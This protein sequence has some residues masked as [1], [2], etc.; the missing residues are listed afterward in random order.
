MMRGSLGLVAAAAPA[1][2]VSA[3][4]P[5]QFFV[6]ALK[7]VIMGRWVHKNSCSQP[8]LWIS[9]VTRSYILETGIDF[10]VLFPNTAT[11]SYAHCEPLLS[12]HIH[13]VHV[14]KIKKTGFNLS[15]CHWCSNSSRTPI[16]KHYFLS[17]MVQEQQALWN[18][19]MR[20]DDAAR[21]MTKQ[22]YYLQKN[23]R[24]FPEYES[25]PYSFLTNICC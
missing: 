25:F 7:P 2:P 16:T 10:R 19:V 24:Q 22:S 11:S 5:V 21:K 6:S 13:L 1:A 12:P 8:D 4:S 15:R 3:L 14:Q 17:Q 9:S 20:K 18:T 23:S